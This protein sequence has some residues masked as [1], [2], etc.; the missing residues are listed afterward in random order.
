M[1]TN[2]TERANFIWSVA[3]L[4]RDTFKRGRYQEV[5]LP[6]TVLRRIDAVLAPTKDEVLAKYHAYRDKLNTM[7]KLLTDA[8]GYA[9]YNTSPYTFERLLADPNNLADNLRAYIAGFSPNMREVLDNFDFHRTI[10]RLDE[11]GLLYL[12][13][14]RF[15]QIDLHPD[16]VPN[17]E[18]GT[19]FEELIR[20]FN[21]ALNENPG[22]H[23]TPRDVI[24]LMVR[25]LIAPDHGA[26]SRPHI[27]RKVYDPCC[28]TGGMLTLAKDA[29]QAL[30][31]QADVYLYGQEVNPETYAV[32]K[33]DLY[34]KDPTG[35]DAEQ[36]AQGSTLAED[37]HVGQAFGYQLANPPYGKDWKMDR[38]AVE[39][40]AERGHAGR[41]GA[42]TPRVSDGQ[43]LFL[44]HMLSHRPRSEDGGGRIAIVMNGS[45]LF[46]G[47]AGS[48]E[49]EIRRWILEHD[50]LEALVA[51]PEQLFY[52]TGIATYV[53]IL[54][55]RKPETR[56]GKVL[57]I[58]AS[59][60]WAPMRKSL[61]DKRREITEAHV[62]QIVEIY[63][64]A[65]H[66]A[67]TDE[68]ESSGV[69]EAI[70]RKDDDTEVR[71][72]Y[73]VFK[74]TD[75]GYRKIRVERPVR[76]N[77]CACETR[78]PRLYE[79]RA[80]EKLAKSRKRDPEA[81]AQAIAEGEAKQAEI[82][83]ML[84]GMD[85]IVTKDVRAFRAAFKQ[86]AEA[87]GL[88]L[89]AAMRDAIVDALGEPDESAEILV[90]RQGRPVPDTDLRD[91]ERV[92]LDRTVADYFAEEI[93]PHV[94]DAWVDEDYVDD[95]DG[96]VGQ[97]GYEINFNRYFYEYE[98]PRPLEAIEADLRTLQDEIVTLLDE[99]MEGG[100]HFESA[101]HLDEE[102]A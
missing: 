11:A 60:L 78:L 84:R 45:P 38:E 102:A 2:F 35:R 57:L 64:G 1:Q 40:E 74:T 101:S 76:M 53:W 20:R 63:Q 32:C 62:A 66:L 34:M 72:T 88:T 16:V 13:I 8:S 37:H 10:E 65:T 39:R 79:Q 3:D 61:G 15:N 47:D 18:M 51:L 29:I 98:P 26:L 52:N 31:P 55:N 5:I 85:P 91:Y 21:E 7:T 33:S 42:G 70:F 69:Q 25:L 17:H 89:Y 41:F 95:L 27:V 50:W 56:E 81:R 92:P 86:A 24:N 83:D 71:C 4:I 80:F 87:R 99:V 36:I 100:T 30:N 68:R 59:E 19:I 6:F 90:D 9:F 96:G 12:V 77:F 49:S 22:E 23:F 48:G 75:F 97:V 94:P 73:R 43:L 67:A 28:G 58:D 54:S 82:L 44:Q 93:A 46:T 14:E